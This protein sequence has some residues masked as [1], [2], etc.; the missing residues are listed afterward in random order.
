[1]PKK[2]KKKFTSRKTYN[3]SKNSYVKMQ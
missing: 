1:M 3:S 2:Y